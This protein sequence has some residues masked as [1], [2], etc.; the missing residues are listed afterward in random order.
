MREGVLK[1]KKTQ[2]PKKTKTWSN[3]KTD[4]LYTC[5][6][7]EHILMICKF[8]EKG[9]KLPY[10]LIFS[11]ATSDMDTI[12]FNNQGKSKSG[13]V[14]KLLGEGSLQLNGKDTEDAKTWITRIIY[15]LIYCLF[16]IFIFFSFDLLT[17]T[18]S[19][20]FFPLQKNSNLQFQKFKPN[21]KP[22]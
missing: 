22:K 15:L 20:F 10:K 13:I 19:S 21:L 17:Y 4:Q 11:L 9:S 18:L 6:L 14:I 16:F 1:L 7:I 8:N 3:L 2:E 12:T 5:F